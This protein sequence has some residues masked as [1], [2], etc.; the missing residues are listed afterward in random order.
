MHYSRYHKTFATLA[1]AGLLYLLSGCGFYSHTGASVPVDAKTFSVSYINNLASIVSPTLSQVLTEKLKR[2]F[3]NETQLKLTQDEGDIQFSGKI[4][5]YRNAPVAVQ[6]NQVNAVNRLTVVAEIECIN[7]KDEKKNFKQTFTNFVDYSADKTFS[8]IEPELIT[9]VTDMMVTDI[10]N[11][12][13]IN[14]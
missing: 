11:K 9:Q 3:I 12:A 6:G 7:K 2:K 10:F 8:A 5:D 14:W 1:T 4:T 13:F